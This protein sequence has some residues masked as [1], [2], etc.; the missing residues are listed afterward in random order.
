MKTVLDLSLNQYLYHSTDILLLEEKSYL[1]NQGLEFDY[2]GD[3]ILSLSSFFK[4]PSKEVGSES[5]WGT[6]GS[7]I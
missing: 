2:T 5:N 3:T 7:L 4:E 1:R 6:V